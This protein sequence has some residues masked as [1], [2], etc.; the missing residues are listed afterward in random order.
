[1]IDAFVYWTLQS[2]PQLK[3]LLGA[4]DEDSRI[5]PRT[6]RKET[7]AIV[8]KVVPVAYDGHIHTDRIELRI[9]ERDDDRLRSIQTRALSL[10]VKRDGEGAKR[11]T[12]DGETIAVFAC[13]QNGGGELDDE[14]DTHRLLY[15]NVTWRAV[16]G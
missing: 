4:T 11:F 10:L 3:A 16:N 7:R 15:F 8:Y 9:I 2:D 1:M 12:C 14:Y 6:T 13:K 5:D